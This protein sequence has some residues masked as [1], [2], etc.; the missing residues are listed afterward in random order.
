MISNAPPNY[1]DL[2]AFHSII[3]L[4]YLLLPYYYIYYIVIFNNI[5]TVGSCSPLKSFS[6]YDS[7]FLLSLYQMS[8]PFGPYIV[9]PL[10]PLNHWGCSFLKFLHI[11]FPSLTV[12][13]ISF[14]REISNHSPTSGIIPSTLIYYRFLLIRLSFMFL[15]ILVTL[16]A[17]QK[18]PIKSCK[19]LGLKTR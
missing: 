7:T 9:V 10:T 17:P 12:T 5:H 11:H 14:L 16:K 6:K 15:F 13:Q 3:L 1:Q 19:T 18:W 4:L 2:I 8:P